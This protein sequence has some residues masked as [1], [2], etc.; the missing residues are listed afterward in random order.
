MYAYLFTVIVHSTQEAEERKRSMTAASKHEKQ[1][2][3]RLGSR[4]ETLCYSSS[5]KLFNLQHIYIF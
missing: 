3:Y 2:Y 5:Y 4:S 1:F